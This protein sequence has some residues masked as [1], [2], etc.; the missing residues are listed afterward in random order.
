MSDIAIRVENLGKQYRIGGK[1]AGYRT[2]REAILKS[3]TA[4]VRWMRGERK[5]YE[6]F[7]ALDDVSFEIKQGEAVG[8]IC[9]NG[10]RESTV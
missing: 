2:F 8:I 1:Q 6:T 10:D 5:S 3:V 4:P 9:R 7:W